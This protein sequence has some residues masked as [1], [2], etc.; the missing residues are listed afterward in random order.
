MRNILVCCPVYSPHAGG[1]GQ[2]FPLLVR[3]LLSF[4]STKNVVVLT[5]FHPNEKLYTFESGAHV[6]RLLPQ[7]DTKVNK[8]KIYSIISFLLT[9]FLFCFLL[10]I[11]LLKYKVNI[12]HY[13][14]F[15]R[16]PFY[17]L[18]AFYKNIFKIKIILDMRTTVESDKCI[19]NL[20]GYSSMISNSMGVY[21]QMIDLGISVKKNFFVPNPIIFP[22]K[23]KSND[24]SYI[25]KN[26]GIEPEVPYLL[27]VG[28]LLE[29]KSII[30][31]IDAFNIFQELHPDFYLVLVGR[32]M[33]GDSI[34]QKLNENKKIIHIKPVNREKVVALMQHAE[35]IVQPSK[36][37][38]IPRVSLEALSLNK[39]VLLP[40]CVPEFIPK[41][42]VFS[43]RNVTT[44][45]IVEAILRIYKTNDLP[46]YD[47]SVHEPN[48]SI[49]VLNKVYES[50]SNIT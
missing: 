45:E 29:R 5:E 23:L 16:V 31:V 50:T 15:L 39:K 20:F 25:V 30:E 44:K 14:R 38:G 48:E 43:V 6:F 47:L 18:M 9:Y 49:K 4:K 28:Q 34:K 2:Y 24:A 33:M 22:K 11:L 19:T 7:R 40:P 46:K 13:T 26:L 12:I 1:G 42:E 37:E 21:N 8:T 36:V 41:N 10:P 32:N 17:L 3:Q 35:M 27:F